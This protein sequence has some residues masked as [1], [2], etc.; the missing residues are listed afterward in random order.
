MQ[1]PICLCHLGR[2]GWAPAQWSRQQPDPQ[3]LWVL[4]CRLCKDVKRPLVQG[5]LY[6]M[7]Q[8]AWYFDRLGENGV[9]IGADII[10]YEDGDPCYKAAH[11]RPVQGEQLQLADSSGSGT[12]LKLTDCGHL[13]WA[14]VRSMLM[15]TNGRTPPPEELWMTYYTQGRRMECYMEEKYRTIASSKEAINAMAWHLFQVLR[16]IH[17]DDREAREL[18]EVRAGFYQIQ[19]VVWGKCGWQW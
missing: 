17:C 10:K 5:A 19:I 14:L 7:K 8:V 11:H 15:W 3:D 1:C 13:V 12:S 6:H 18:L 9:D 16:Y 2:S 4:G